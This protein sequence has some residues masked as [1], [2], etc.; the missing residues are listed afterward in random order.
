MPPVNVDTGY[1]DGGYPKGYAAVLASTR[2]LTLV[3]LGC[4][5]ETTATM[6]TAPALRQCGDLYQKEF[7]ATSQ[8]SAAN[9]FL[10]RHRNQVAAVSIDVGA[11]DLEHC[12]S[13]SQV[14][15]SCLKSDDVKTMRN[16]TTILGSLRTTLQ[17]TNPSAQL[18]SMNYYDP[19][20]GLAFSPG[21]T[22]GL[23]LAASSLVATDIFN[24]ELSAVLRSFGVPRADVASTFG[25][26]RFVPL[27][28]YSGMLVPENVATTCKLTWMCSPGS[29]QGRDIHPNN[30]GYQA[31]AGAFEKVLKP[32]GGT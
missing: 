13:S 31:I 23:K 15:L 29:S 11:N 22:D 10:S 26:N 6:M 16:L 8:L 3:D 14:S 17:R 2:R 21:G 9:V 12:V 27:T 32:S 18:V 19:F 25:V 20:L 5:G 24:T 7:R 4:P 28:R 1:R 30:A